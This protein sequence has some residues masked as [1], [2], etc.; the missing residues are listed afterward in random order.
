MLGVEERYEAG[1]E[2]R[3]EYPRSTHAEFRRRGDIDP[4]AVLLGQ[5]VGRIDTLVPVRHR[6]MAEDAFAFFRA[7]AALMAADLGSTTTTGLMVQA[8][9]DAHVGNFGFYGSPE[10]DL[11][12]DANDFDETLRASFEWDLKRLAASVVIAARDNGFDAKDQEQAALHAVREYR[13]AMA[14]FASLGLL[15]VWYAHYSAGRLLEQL[16][17][18]GKERKAREAEHLIEKA[19]AKDS[20]HVLRKLAEK[21]GGGYRIKDEPPWLVPIRSMGDLYPPDRIQALVES[22]FESYIDT[23]PAN[24]ATLARKYTFVDAALKVVGVGSVGTRCFVLLLSGRDEEDPLFLQVKE[25]SPSVLAPRFGGDPHG[26]EGQRVVE[27]QR[28]MQ[29][30]SDVF[31]GWLTGGTSGRQYYVRQLK[32]MKASVDISQL[33]PRAMRRYVGACAWTLAQSHARSGDAVTL[34]GYMGSGDV[35]AEAITEFALAYADQNRSDYKAFLRTA[36]EPA[37]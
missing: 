32:D 10:R 30:T 3:K 29:A 27:V 8:S 23:L 6:R 21:V 33:D 15:D 22:Q 35:L 25:A 18:A 7:G 12:F 34:A 26:H 36:A 9:G 19:K 2:L 13:D 31:L 4:T 20:R 17:A 1:K 11:V 14:Q 16:R 28:L 5:D 24:V 37:G